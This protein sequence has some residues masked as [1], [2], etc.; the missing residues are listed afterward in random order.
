M[1]DPLEHV[2]R[3]YDDAT[4]HDVLI[5]TRARYAAA[6]DPDAPGIARNIVELEL[7]ALR[8]G[9]RIDAGDDAEA[10][11]AW[12]RLDALRQAARQKDVAAFR[13]AVKGAQPP[14]L[15]E[16][17]PLVYEFTPAFP[18]IRSILRDVYFWAVFRAEDYDAAV[19]ALYMISVIAIYP[20]RELPLLELALCDALGAALP[21][22]SVLAAS[23]RGWSDLNRFAP[24][25]EWEP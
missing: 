1:R 21:P 23:R 12:K 25:E 3:N 6:A 7:E 11:A 8:R 2:L 18:D 17:W 19:S 22:N 20:E 15:L 24:P 5:A 14:D 16:A 9:L 10:A 4:L 13:E